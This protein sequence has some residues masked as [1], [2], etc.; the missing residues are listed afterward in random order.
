MRVRGNVGLV[1]GLCFA[2]FVANAAASEAFNFDRDTFAFENETVFEYHSGHASPRWL[3]S[4]DRP[5]RFTSHCFVMSRAVVQFRKFARFD[6]SRPALDD[7]ELA[8]RIRKVTRQPPWRPPLPE[9]DRLVI[10]GY[11]NLR[12]LSRERAGIVQENIGLGWPTYFRPG[13][14]RIV[15]PHDP[16]R[17]A[18]THLALQ[19]A[20]QSGD[21]FFVAYLTTF[22]TSLSINH[23]VL[24]YKRNAVR[25]RGD[26]K[27][28]RYLVYDPNHSNLPRLLDWSERDRCF[29]YQP[30]TD[31]VGGRV[32]VWQVFGQPIQ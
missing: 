29:S 2:L 22:P 31:F 4:G 11:G 32:I 7:S 8:V 20:L 28:T 26:P 25:D 23:A 30:D 9:R 5:R 19:R 6:P 21:G 17:Q 16:A 12:T 13:N 3:T 27:T 24:V 18:R 10:P 1:V 14:W 15:L